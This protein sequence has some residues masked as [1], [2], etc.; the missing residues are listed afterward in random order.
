MLDDEETAE[1]LERHGR[2]GREIERY[3]HLPMIRQ[4][5]PPIL[6][7]IT[8]TADTAQVATHSSFTDHEAQLL[9]FAMGLGSAPAGILL[10]QASNQRTD[11][12]SRSRSTAA[13]P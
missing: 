2:N 11:L 7:S 1:K 6:S 5:G 12:S 4:E 10:R 8:A 9:E 3:D 13:R